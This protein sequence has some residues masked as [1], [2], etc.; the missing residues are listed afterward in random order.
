MLQKFLIAIYAAIVLTGCATAY[1]ESWHE[2]GGFKDERLHPEYP[3]YSV[4]SSCNGFTSSEQCSDIALRRA[5]EICKD[6]SYDGFTVMDR[7]HR[8]SQS[9]GQYTY[10]TTET[11]R[12]NVSATYS[13]NYGYSGY[14]NAYATTTYQQP[15][16]VY[17]TVNKP[18]TDMAIGCLKRKDYRN[19]SIVYDSYDVLNRTA[20]LVK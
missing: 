7:N 12:T 13:N 20:Y 9:Q 16:T 8:V 6:H 11:V 17:Y 19:F 1:H 14:G 4:Q 10:N 15:H 2:D 18:R 5:A 3:I